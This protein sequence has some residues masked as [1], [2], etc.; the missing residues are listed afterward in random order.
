MPVRLVVLVVV[1]ILVV[2][3][4]AAR[5]SP[6]CLCLRQ[7]G[8][9]KHADSS[10]CHLHCLKATCLGQGVAH[11]SNDVLSSL[12][13]PKILTEILTYSKKFRKSYPRISAGIGHGFFVSHELQYSSWTDR[14]LQSGPNCPRSSQDMAETWWTYYSIW[15]WHKMP[16]L[17]RMPW[18]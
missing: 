7:E 1:S 3:L 6:S 13:F 14:V 11:D 4:C 16:S 10:Q 18:A 8:L 12:S 9:H 17:A 15:K 5:P 2:F